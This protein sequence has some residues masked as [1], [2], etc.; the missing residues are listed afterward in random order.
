MSVYVVY[1]EDCSAVAHVAKS[2]KSAE[3]YTK[4]MHKPY[5][6]QYKH[7]TATQAGVL[8]YAQASFFEAVMEDQNK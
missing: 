8:S 2:K 6:R 7:L 3:Q 4:Q 1:T 5:V